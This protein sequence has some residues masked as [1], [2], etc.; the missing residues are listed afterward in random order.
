MHFPFTKSRPNPKRRTPRRVRDRVRHHGKR[1]I[2]DRLDA[3]R[4]SGGRC[5]MS[6]SGVPEIFIRCDRRIYL[7]TFHWAHER[8]GC[9]KSDDK[10]KASCRECHL[11]QHNAGGKPVKKKPGR[12]MTVAEARR[13]LRSVVCFCESR[14]VA[15]EV[16]CFPCRELLS[17]QTRLDLKTLTNRAYLEALALAEIEI[18]SRREGVA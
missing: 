5:E 8:H 18:I 3:F 2:E 13:Y 12:V 1:R 15:G 10:A 9:N 16:F 17:E 14:K 4:R 6:V 11:A 7:S